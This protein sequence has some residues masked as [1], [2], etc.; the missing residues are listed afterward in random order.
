MAARCSAPLRLLDEAVGA[1]G[2]HSGDTIIPLRQLS[3]SS[4]E[5]SNHLV[6]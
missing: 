4:T 3:R 2:R 6:P 5:L 1:K